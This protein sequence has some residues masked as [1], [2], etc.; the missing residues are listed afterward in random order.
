MDGWMREEDPPTSTKASSLFLFLVP[1][2]CPSIPFVVVDTLW[3]I[4]FGQKS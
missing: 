4:S 1:S 3:D 2:F